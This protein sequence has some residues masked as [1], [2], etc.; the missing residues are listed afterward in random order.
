MKTWKPASAV[1]V[2]GTHQVL[3]LQG[4]RVRVKTSMLSA[5]LHDAIGHTQHTALLAAGC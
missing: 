4:T 3:S 1:F 5:A 2:G